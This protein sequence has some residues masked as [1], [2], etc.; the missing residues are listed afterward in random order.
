M[1]LDDQMEY[2]I[3]LADPEFRAEVEDVFKLAALVEEIAK[4]R[5][6]GAVASAALD[7]HFC[8]TIKAAYRANGAFRHELEGFPAQSSFFLGCSCSE[9]RLQCRRKE[10][11]T[12]RRFRLAQAKRRC[13]RC[14]GGIAQVDEADPV[15]PTS[16]FR[17][18]R[19][20]N[21]GDALLGDMNLHSL[22]H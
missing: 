14:S 2:A 3:R 21:D 16:N 11:L 19:G 12:S 10:R 17:T 1:Q 15:R 18:S 4:L 13:S 6:R 22:P 8:A 20:P 7:R 5:Q 9:C